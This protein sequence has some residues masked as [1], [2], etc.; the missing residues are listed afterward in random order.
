MSHFHDNAAVKLP[1]ANAYV[2]NVNYLYKAFEQSDEELVVSKINHKLAAQCGSD[3]KIQ[4]YSGHELQDIPGHVLTSLAECYAQVFNEGWGESW[5][6][7]SALKEIEHCIYCQDDYIPVMSLLFREEKVIGFSWGFIMDTDCLSDDSA[8][9]SSSGLKRHE[10]VSVARY[11]LDVIGKK[12]RLISIRELGVLKEYRQDKTP[13]LTIPMFEKAKRLECK[14]AFLRTKVTSKAFK[15]CLGVG[16]VP[17]QLFMVDG[18]LLM[19]G[20]ISYAM[21]LLYGM[22]EDT[23]KKKSQGEMVANIKRYLC[24]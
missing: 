4:F 5:T 16:F 22:I 17:L 13:F 8:P 11:W 1:E 14:V 24:Q 15:W 7:E 10:S 2:R 12:N 3:F 21:N 6:I 9:F 20:S 19:Q 18:L 23:R